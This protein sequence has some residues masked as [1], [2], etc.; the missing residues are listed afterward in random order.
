MSIELF[1]KLNK[2]HMRVLQ[3]LIKVRG[4]DFT[5]SDVAR[6][7]DLTRVTLYKI[8]KRLEL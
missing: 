5:I 7:T 2:A 3:Y 1:S 6:S 8:W 4:L